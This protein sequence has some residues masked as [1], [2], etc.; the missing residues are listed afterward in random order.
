MAVNSLTCLFDGGE[1][2]IDSNRDG[3]MEGGGRSTALKSRCGGL[4]QAKERCRYAGWHG[5][6]EN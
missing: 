1:Q 4:K 3:I 5:C 2:V 6:H